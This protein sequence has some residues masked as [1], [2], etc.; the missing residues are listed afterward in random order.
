MNAEIK[1]PLEEIQHQLGRIVG[2][3][4]VINDSKELNYYSTDV[5]GSDKTAVLT[6]QPQSTDQVS[7]IVRLVTD[8]G[9]CLVS[10]GGGMSYTGGYTPSQTNT[11]MIDT[12]ALNR[13]LEINEDDMVITVEAGVTWQQIHQAL[14]PRGLRLPFFGTYSGRKA[15]VGGGIANGA[16]FMG[17]A[18]YGTAAEIVLGLE[19]VTSGGRVITTGQK[20]FSKG[21]AYYRSYG[22]DLT[23]VFVHDAGTLGVKTKISLRLIQTPDHTDCLSFVFSDVEH[24]VRG[25]SAVARSGVA[26]EAYVFDPVS[27]KKSLADSDLRQDFRR[28]LGVI[29]GQSSF[30][31]GL[32]EGAKLVATGRNFMEEGLYS[33]HVVCASRSEAGLKADM[34]LCR[35]IMDQQQGAEI[36]HSIPVTMRSNPFE[37]LNGI[38][39]TDGERWAALNAKVAHSDAE[40][41]VLRTKE[42]FAKY[43]SEMEKHRVFWTH[44]MIAI[45]NHVFS[46]EPVLRWYDEWLPIHKRTPEPAHLKKLNEPA[47]NPEGRAL[48]DRI[49]EEVVALFAELGAASTQIGKTYLY[50][51]SLNE[52]TASLLM[53]IK[54]EL[55]PDG[56]IN[57]GAMG[58]PVNP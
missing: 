24:T 31:K 34:Q 44:L 35:E 8:A 43:E 29:K 22:P 54:R 1:P 30:A 58:L 53:S 45:S 36:P 40:Q 41:L 12:Q 6:V 5:Y 7:D 14:T 52:E 47:P 23:G 11:V 15:T 16:L 39:G 42:I 56:L 38:L 19:V 3:G 48:V 37:H 21:R 17:T 13:I 26:E 51:S 33:V 4:H 27:T 2:V 46:F 9:L 10:R 55:D 28:L 18:R 49:R 57:P 32:R 50:Y 25:L 20:A